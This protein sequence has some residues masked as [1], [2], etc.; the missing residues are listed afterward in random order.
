MLT[1]HWPKAPRTRGDLERL[2]GVELGPSEWLEVGQASVDAFAAVTG[3][4]QWIHVD[5]ARAAL[6]PLGTTIAHGLLTL[7]YGPALTSRL[8]S[9]DAFPHVLNYGYDKVRFPA[10]LRVGSRVRAHVVVTAVD[11]VPGG[12]QVHMSQ[13]M[14]AEG[15]QRPV[16]VAEWI[17][18]VIEG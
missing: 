6:S 15:L 18:R 1:R 2:V 13:V 9:L 10:P 14:T 16:A 11:E 17:L 7:S 4:E 12:L 5:P 3:D 8:L